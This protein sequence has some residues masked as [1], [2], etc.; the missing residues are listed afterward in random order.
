MGS[1]GRIYASMCWSSRIHRL[2][3]VG[4]EDSA[5][6]PLSD[7][8]VYIGKLHIPLLEKWKAQSVSSILIMWSLRPTSCW[9]ILTKDVIRLICR[10]YVLDAFFWCEAF[11]HCFEQTR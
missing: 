11:D 9:S 3:L 6:Q 5:F 2:F 1:K 7:N 4:G 10:K 8:K